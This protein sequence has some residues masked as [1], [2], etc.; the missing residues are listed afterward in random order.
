FK[1]TRITDRIT[2][3]PS[4]ETYKASDD[5]IIIE[6]DPGMAFGTGTHPTTTLCLKLL[7]QFIVEGESTVLDIG[8]GSG[9]LTIAASKLG[10]KEVTGVEI[11]PT[12]VRVA[13]KNIEKNDVKGQIRIV[14]G[15]L[16]KGLDYTADII[17]ANL[18]AELIMKLGMHVP[19]HLRQNGIFISSGILLEKKEEV[20][21]SLKSRGFQILCSPED[22]EW[23]AIAAKYYSD[24]KDKV[25]Q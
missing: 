17:V 12:A 16:T 18:M 21:T 22:E 11:D 10:A 9:I 20:I 14:E 6:I 2:V 25:E 7:E 5:E 13:E 4:W 24:D 23:C 15:D 3:L 19:D 1:P 8:C